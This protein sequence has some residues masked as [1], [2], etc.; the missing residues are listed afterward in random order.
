MAEGPGKYD[1]ACTAAREITGG[2]VILI[3]IGGKKGA[4]FSVQG[5]DASTIL[6]LP[7]ILEQL[8]KQLRKDLLGPKQ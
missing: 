7:D 6:L 5:E 3:V 8:S 2:N 4:G 1:D